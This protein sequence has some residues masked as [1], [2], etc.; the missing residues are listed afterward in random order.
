MEKRE[1]ESY[2]IP[3]SSEKG[4]TERMKEIF[5]QLASKNKE[6]T[7]ADFARLAKEFP[8][9]E[10]IVEEYLR[11][12]TKHYDKIRKQAAHAAEK[13]LNKYSSGKYSLHEILKKMLKYKQEYKWSDL[14]YDE[15]RKALFN[16]LTGQQALQVEY[17]QNIMVNRSRISQTLG[18]HRIVE[19]GLKIKDSEQGILAEIL[20]MYDKWL[21]LHNAIFINSLTYED[22]SLAAIT[23]TFSR[24]RNI[25]SNFI[26]PVIAAMFLPKFNIFETF[27]IYANIGKIVKLRY[28]KQPILTEP[29]A[30]LYGNFITDPNDVVC[31]ISSAITDLRNRY[32]V[33]VTLWETILRLRQGRYYEAGPMSDFMASLNACRNNIYDNADLIYNQDEGSIIRKIMSVFSLRPTLIVTRPISSVALLGQV[34]FN[35][36]SPGQCSTGTSQQG[37]FM[38]NPVYTITSIPM[39][40]INI[41][42]YYN[43]RCEPIE[44]QNAMNQTVWINENKTI[45]PKEQAI[46]YSNEVIIFYVNRRVQRIQIRAFT[47]PLCFS[48]LPMTMS[49]LDRLNNYPLIVN[50]S[51][52][53]A[54]V[55]ETY[56]LR[57]VVAVTETSIIHRGSESRLITGSTAMIASKRNPMAGIFQPEYFL[58]DPLGAAIPVKHPYFEDEENNPQYH[59]YIT[60]KPISYIA[61]FLSEGPP[62]APTFADR[63]CHNGT[64][65]IYAKPTGY[66]VDHILSF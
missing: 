4:D 25:A 12:R 63:A 32:Q 40:N 22:C 60:N 19:E 5:R 47:N 6:P 65:F 16:R 30:L 37:P 51:I 31:E 34:G 53:I 56:D 48:Q 62:N 46:L 28:E 9:N 43:E 55:N 39:F 38:G 58:Y 20:R 18:S 64:I 7:E 42:P 33:Q 13:I 2:H 23:G 52:K 50:D 66:T 26:H 35:F 45:I 15:F 14:E 17:N 29:D 8:N 1:R 57:S 21:P 59:G 36:M 3:S 44:L 10:E 11:F 49:G 41:P 27:M 24:D 54:G 61:K